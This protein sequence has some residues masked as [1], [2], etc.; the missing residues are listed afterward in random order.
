[1]DVEHTLT[2][3]HSSCIH[4]TCVKGDHQ[5][6]FDV[7]AIHKNA[8]VEDDCPET[9]VRSSSSGMDAIGCHEVL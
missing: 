9:D 3:K 4:R 6:R 2:C 1:V 5:Q 7:V 8:C